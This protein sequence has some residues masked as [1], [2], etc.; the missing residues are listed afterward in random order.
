MTVRA[1]VFSLSLAL[2]SAAPTLAQPPGPTGSLTLMS[3]PA[4][5]WFRLEGDVV[6]V[7]R[8]PMTLSR[9]LTGRFRV[10]GS[11]IGYQRWSRTLEL[12]GVTADTVWIALR[13]KSAFKAGV[14]SLLLP[15]WGQF[16]DEH[17]VRATIF[18]T[19][20][21]VVGSGIGVNEIIH[22]SRLDHVD[23]ARA[24]YL[25]D[26][27]PATLDALQ[28]AEGRAD[29]CRQLRKILVGVGAG[30]VLLSVIDAVASVPRPVGTIVLGALQGGSNS[31][32]SGSPGD[33]PRFALTFAQVKF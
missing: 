2:V 14:R 11:D 25:A 22:H 8:T 32:L 5:A 13:E 6:V 9:G 18:L 29:D 20:G 19:T 15:G 17:P 7:G 4:G 28:R 23:A 12:D 3:R 27:T 24:A 16:Y 33:G 1:A 21:I 26:Q 30:V 10:S 31:G